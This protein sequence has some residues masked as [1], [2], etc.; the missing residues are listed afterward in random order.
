MKLRDAGIDDLGPIYDVWYAT[1]IDGLTDP[2]PP[3]AMPWFGHLLDVGRLV[4]AVDEGAG[5]DGRDEVVGFAAALD[6]GRCVALSD[7]F[8][9]PDQQS[10]GVGGALLDEV[11]PPGRPLVTMASA[12]P[13]AVASYARRGLRPRWP[14]YYL[15]ASPAEL[16]PGSWPDLEV[17]PLP[18]DH[19][20]WQ[21]R[22]R[23][24]ALRADRRPRS[25]GA[26]RGP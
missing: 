22:G 16:R 18:A 1:E 10:R 15:A 23:R 13:R 14:A 7:L 3:G 20:P 6:H 4:V 5:A 17:A 9:R 19:Y 24:R 2:P 8:V 21:L 11:L 12:D 26:G 25:R